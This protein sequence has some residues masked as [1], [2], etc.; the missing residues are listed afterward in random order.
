MSEDIEAVETEEH[1]GLRIPE[2]LRR[3]LLKVQGGKMYLPVAARMIW[4]RDKFPIETGWAYAT[5][6]I[7]GG[8]QAEFATIQATIFNPAGQIIATGIKTETKNDFPQGHVEKAETGAI[9][10][11]LGGCGFGTQFDPSL[12]EDGNRPCDA[13]QSIGGQP[14]IWP[15][16]DLCPGCN[17]P[18]GKPH[19]KS[20]GEGVAHPQLNPAPTQPAAERDTPLAAAR[21]RFFAVFA[22][23][24]FPTNDDYCRKVIAKIINKRMKQSDPAWK[25]ISVKTRTNLPVEWWNMA[26]DYLP[27]YKDWLLRHGVTPGTEFVFDGE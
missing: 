11:A 8:Y 26:A 5:N 10:R 6:I 4:F 17:A 2:K 27:T 25:E 9:G 14:R 13:P 15:G 3:F 12:E 16:P 22:E 7:E 24:G 23:Q 18:A 19:V 1:V 20:C 21:K